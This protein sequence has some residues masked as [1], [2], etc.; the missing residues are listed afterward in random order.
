MKRQFAELLH[1]LGFVANRDPRDKEVNINSGMK[2]IV[3]CAHQAF[4]VFF[5]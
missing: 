3:C 2:A 1:D 4:L 5:L